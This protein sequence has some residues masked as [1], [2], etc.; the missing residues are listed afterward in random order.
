MN[1]KNV[2]IAFL[3]LNLGLVATIGRTE[4]F[5]KGYAAYQAGDYPTASAIF[6]NLGQ[7]GDAHAQFNLGLMY[8]QGEGVPQDYRQA[9][10]WFRGRAN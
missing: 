2:A 9:V 7:M 6:K 1:L 5:A 3:A 4:S 10:H 8:D